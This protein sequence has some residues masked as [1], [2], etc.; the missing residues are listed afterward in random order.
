[1]F[2]FLIGTLK[3]PKNDFVKRVIKGFNSS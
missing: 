2:Q 3:T 1:V